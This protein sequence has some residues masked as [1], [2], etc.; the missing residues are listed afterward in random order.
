MNKAFY[1]CATC[2]YH[3]VNLEK[4]TCTCLL[5]KLNPKRSDLLHTKTEPWV[6]S[7]SF[8]TSFSG[9]G[10]IANEIIR[11]FHQ[12]ICVYHAQFL[13]CPGYEKEKE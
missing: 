11:H 10:S 6:V 1:K 5:E 7:G 12:W 4:E 13:N 8:A 9:V 3:K 2:I